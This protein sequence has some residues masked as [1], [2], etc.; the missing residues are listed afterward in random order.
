D[1]SLVA[2][3]VLPHHCILSKKVETSGNVDLDECE[4]NFVVYL[5]PYKDALIRV[6]GV[7]VVTP[8]KLTPGDLVSLGE[9]YVFM[10]KDPTHTLDKELKLHW[11]DVLQKSHALHKDGDYS[12]VNGDDQTD[13]IRFPYKVADEER[14]LQVVM[15][16][17]D[18]DDIYP[19][20]PAY[21]LL[22]AVKHSATHHTDTQT[23]Q[24]LLRIANAIQTIVWEKTS[25]MSN[26]I[27]KD[28]APS[29]ALL[30]LLPQLRPV[31]CWMANCLEM[32]HYL[33][34]NLSR[35]LGNASHLS[36]G[37][38]ALLS[39][40]EEMLICLEEVVMYSF[41]QTVYHLTKVLYV[42]LPVILDTNPFQFEDDDD[43]AGKHPQ[44]VDMVVGIFNSTH[45]LLRGCGVHEDISRQLFAYLFFFANASLFNT[46]MERGAGGK[47]YRWAKGAQIRGNLDALEAWASQV[48]LQ[49]EYVHYLQRLS[50][51]VDLLATPKV[52]LL[53]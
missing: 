44:E 34:A 32:L 41:Q 19:L 3:D 23:R 21:L 15:G 11:L 29:K 33:Q 5:E 27:D 31:I 16:L 49:D 18:E 48:G 40:D 52:Q 2:P 6:N 22:L 1:I 7:S 24:L 28:T 25:D 35:Y 10:F 47:F 51:A 30:E 53:Q 13:K 8:I 20:T 26:T 9:Y 14:M 50:T 36:G 4:V 12:V 43:Q 39:A 38:E 37:E 46:L 17:V 45:F 42:A